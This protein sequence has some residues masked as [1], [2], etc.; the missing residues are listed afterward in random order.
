[1]QT[2]Y[3]SV[4][5][6]RV[7]D[8]SFECNVNPACISTHCRI[9]GMYTGW[10]H[11]HPCTSIRAVHLLVLFQ[12]IKMRARP[13]HERVVTTHSQHRTSTC[14]WAVNTGDFPSQDP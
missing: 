12:S 8:T 5:F 10:G 3:L 14:E 2:S 4:C 7:A 9:P 11:V 13:G 1:M 6:P